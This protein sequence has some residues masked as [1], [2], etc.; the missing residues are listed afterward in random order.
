MGENHELKNRYMLVNAPSEWSDGT[1]AG[2]V[3]EKLYTDNP[4]ITDCTSGGR[5]RTVCEGNDG[6]RGTQRSRQFLKSLSYPRYQRRLYPYALS[7]LSSP[8]SPEVSTH[9]EGLGTVQ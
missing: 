5:E 8:S 3:Q 7:R 1:D 4:N 6:W 9:G 2:Q